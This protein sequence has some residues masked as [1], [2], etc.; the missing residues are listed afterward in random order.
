VNCEGASS[1]FDLLLNLVIIASVV[2]AI[3]SRFQLFLHVTFKGLVSSLSHYLLQPSF[4]KLLCLCKREKER[5]GGIDENN[6]VRRRRGRGGEGEGEEEEDEEERG[7]ARAEKWV[8]MEPMELE[9][10]KEQYDQDQNNHNHDTTTQE[11]ATSTRGEGGGARRE[12]GGGIGVG[13]EF[14]NGWLYFL[15]FS[16]PSKLAFVVNMVLAQLL[17]QSDVFHLVLQFAMSK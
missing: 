9:E 12:G 5:K 16:S 3:Q 13:R 15:F 2:F 7:E 4:F 1:A 14:D 17:A 10:Q 11:K 6:A 8:K